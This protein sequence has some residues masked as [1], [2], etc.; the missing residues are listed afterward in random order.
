MLSGPFQSQNFEFDCHPA[1]AALAD[2]F[3]FEAWNPFNVSSVHLPGRTISKTSVQIPWGPT[4][5]QAACIVHPKSH[6]VHRWAKLAAPAVLNLQVTM[7]PRPSAGD[8]FLELPAWTSLEWSFVPQFAVYDDKGK[9]FA[10]GESCGVLSLAQPTTMLWVWT[11]GHPVE[12]SLASQLQ[13]SYRGML[14]VHV[15]EPPDTA[16]TPPTISVTVVWDASVPFRGFEEVDLRLESRA[17]GQVQTCKIRIDGSPDAASVA[18]LPTNSTLGVHLPQLL[19]L[20][21]VACCLGCCLYGAWGRLFGP[22]SPGRVLAG[23]PAVAP[24]ASYGVQAPASFQP[25]TASLPGQAAQGASPFR[26]VDIRPY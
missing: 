24:W 26:R 19:I 2:F 9:T 23:Q 16:A 10:A 11:G 22:P 6:D 14:A 7:R 18:E 17:S 3:T 13:K 21:I 20:C 25:Q 8:S 15:S 12:A 1:D 4:S 5:P